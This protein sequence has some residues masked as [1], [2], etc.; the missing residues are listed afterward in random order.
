VRKIIGKGYSCQL[1]LLAKQGFKEAELAIKNEHCLEIDPTQSNTKI[2]SMHEFKGNIQVGKSKEWGNIGDNWKFG[3]L[4]EDLLKR[5]IEFARNYGIPRFVFHPGFTNIFVCTREAALD[6][7]VRR[8]KRIYDSFVN[9]KGRQTR[10]VK[11][12]IENSEFRPDITAYHNERLVVDADHT[13]NLIEKAEEKGVKLSIVVDIEHLY[14]TA[15]F[16]PLYDE[17]RRDYEKISC[18]VSCPIHKQNADNSA[19]ERLLE[20]SRRNEVK[21]QISDFLKDYFERL[22][23]FVEAVHVCGSDF[24][25][26]KRSKK[27]ETTTVGSHLPIGYSGEIDGVHVKDRVDHKEYLNLLDKYTSPQ[28]PLIIEVTPKPEPIDYLQCV[29]DSKKRLMEILCLNF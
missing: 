19:E 15:I 10:G 14:V 2:F 11:L 28:V 8:L 20:F 7:V 4:S 29:V 16:R 5:Q 13:L 23:S 25:N 1:G 26:Y 21:E 17:L 6:T 3:D 9:K 27:S 12:C 24:R 22:G 18:P